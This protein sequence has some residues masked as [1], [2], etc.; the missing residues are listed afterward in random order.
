MRYASREGYHNHLG[1][2]FNLLVRQLL[3]EP[4]RL[5][6]LSVSQIPTVGCYPKVGC[7][8][9]QYLDVANLRQPYQTSGNLEVAPYSQL[10]RQAIYKYINETSNPDIILLKST[11]Q[12]YKSLYIMTKYP[13]VGCFECFFS[14]LALRCNSWK[15]KNV[16][17]LTLIVMQSQYLSNKISCEQSSWVHSVYEKTTNQTSWG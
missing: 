11:N 9:I 1:I 17:S 14:F 16:C 3:C 6:P 5:L 10:I 7:R 4:V 12:I 15:I 13:I 2:I 8:N